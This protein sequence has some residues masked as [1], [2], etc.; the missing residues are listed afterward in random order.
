M[1]RPSVA[2]SLLVLLLITAGPFLHKAQKHRTYRNF[3]VVED[4]VLYRSGQMSPA[5]FER[6]CRERGVRT[7]IK[8][9]DAN[10][11]KPADVAA[12]MAEEGYCR[13]N[14]IVF[15]RVLPKD[16]EV[17]ADGGVPMEENLRWFERAMADPA[18]TPRPVLIHCFAGIHRTGAMVAVYRVKHNKYFPDDAIAELKACGRTTTTYVGNLIPFL[19]DDYLPK[20]WE[21]THGLPVGDPTGGR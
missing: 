20:L 19:R 3:R 13:A 12:D 8:L 16:W 4:G 14:G 11:E 6:V 1:L 7:V 5:G 17:A 18:Q 21:R 2:L 9:R 10:D 15:H